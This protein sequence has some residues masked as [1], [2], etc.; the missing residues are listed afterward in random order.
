MRKD[1]ELITNI[2]LEARRERRGKLG[3][4]LDVVGDE[5]KIKLPLGCL[6]ST[7]FAG[8]WGWRLQIFGMVLEGFYS[9]R[10]FKI[11]TQERAS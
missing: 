3:V 5:M 9:P 6:A 7:Y 11:L 4:W 10:I 8:M 2:L 1:R